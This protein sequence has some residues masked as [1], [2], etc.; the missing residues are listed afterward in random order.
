MASP[1]VESTQAARFSSPLLQNCE[2][3]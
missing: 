2:R 3:S 1:F